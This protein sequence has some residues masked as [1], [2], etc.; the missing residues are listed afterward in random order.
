MLRKVYN[1]HQFGSMNALFCGSNYKGAFLPSSST[2]GA[3][4]HRNDNGSA[5]ISRRGLI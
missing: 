4:L 5:G 1:L 3:D 2:T